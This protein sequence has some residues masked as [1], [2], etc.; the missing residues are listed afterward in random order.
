[1]MMYNIR[2]RKRI[3]KMLKSK[4]EE[5]TSWRLLC[6]GFENMHLRKWRKAVRIGGGDE[7]GRRGHMNSAL[8][9]AAW[10]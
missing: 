4:A 2:A 3:A 7:T 10:L 6:P 1:M 8:A 9:C 5:I